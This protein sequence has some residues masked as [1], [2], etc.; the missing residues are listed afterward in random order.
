MTA[1]L[2]EA[3]LFISKTSAPCVKMALSRPHGPLGP[4]ASKL[5]GV[6]YLPKGSEPPSDSEG[7]PMF[8]LAQTNFSEVPQGVVPGLPTAGLLQ[9]W[10]SGAVGVHGM[11]FRDGEKAFE[12][13]FF[14]NPDPAEQDP[15]ADRLLHVIDA[16]SFEIPPLPFSGEIACA[17]SPSS[18]LWTPSDESLKAPASLEGTEEM[19]E[20]AEELAPALDASGASNL[21]RLGGYAYF[22]QSDP[23][24][25]REAEDWVLLWQ[26]D[27]DGPAD[28]MWG[29][30]GIANA[31]IRREDLEATPPRF[32]RIL[33]NWDCC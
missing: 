8:L 21:H 33:W 22:T 24:F 5:G 29:D 30:S 23:R 17:F 14:P 27:T 20:A 3:A 7:R 25:G 11:G 1:P 9:F 4:T 19:W 32:D 28:I 31:F 12:A 15:S 2:S 26:C 6:P 18:C 13:R 10:V 16:K